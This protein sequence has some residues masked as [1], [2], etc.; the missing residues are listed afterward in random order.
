MKTLLFLHNICLLTPPAC[1]ILFAKREEKREIASWPKW[2]KSFSR[3]RRRRSIIISSCNSHNL[4]AN[5]RDWSS[6][7]IASWLLHRRRLTELQSWRTFQ[8]TSLLKVA[9]ENKKEIPDSLVFY[10]WSLKEMK[11]LFCFGKQTHVTNILF[12][13]STLPQRQWR[14]EI[15]IS[16]PPFPNIKNKTQV[17]RRIWFAL[18]AFRKEEGEKKVHFC[19][20]TILLIISNI[21]PCC[22]RSVFEECGVC[23]FAK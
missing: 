21:R 2:K 9:E 23:V 10:S 1:L 18:F 22:F 13:S 5:A 11:V 7:F 20:N 16:I 14:T 12:W 8:P 15:W 6:P 17:K 4:I 3:R 19:T